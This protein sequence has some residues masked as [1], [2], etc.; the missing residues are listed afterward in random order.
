MRFITQIHHIT[1]FLFLLWFFGS[2]SAQ[3]S[4]TAND[5]VVPYSGYFR[6]GSNLGYLPLGWSNKDAA[7]LVAGNPA[8]GIAGVGARSVRPSLAH[9]VLHQFGDQIE[10]DEFE[11]YFNLGM[12]DLTAFV[13]EPADEWRD[14][15]EY[16]PGHP[17]A[18]FKNLY[19][20]IWDG[21]ANGTPVNDENYFALYMYRVVTKYKDYVK[22]WEIWNEPGFAYTD[23]GWKNPGQPGNWWENDPEPCDYKL[24]API[25]HYIRTLRIAYEVVKY[26]S[27]GDYVVV[28]GLGYPS[29]L[30]AIL[31]NT[32]NPV[33]GGVTPEFPLKGGAYFDV[34]GI[35]SYPSIDGTLRHWDNSVQ[36]WAYMRTSDEAAR[37]IFDDRFAKYEAV[38]ANYGYDGVT[39]PKKLR[40]ITETNVPRKKFTVESLASDEGQCNFLMKA[41]ILNKINDV[42]QMHVY[43]IDDEAYEW[44]I[45]SEFQS[46]GFYKKFSGQPENQVRNHSAIAFKTVAD[47]ITETTYDPQRTAQLNV[48]QGV[49]G[50][51]FKRFDGTYVY[52]LWAKT[53]IDNSEYASATYSFPAEMGISQ[54]TRYDWDYSDTHQSSV[55]DA[56]G[57]PLT[58]RPSFFIVKAGADKPPAVTLH[59]DNHIVSGPFTLTIVF[60]K[61]VTGFSI[62][63]IQVTNSWKSDFA[64]SG[65]SYTVRIHPAE[66]GLVTARVPEA[67]ATDAAGQAN[68]ASL[69]V[70]IVYRYCRPQGNVTYVH[71]KEVRLNALP[72][73]SG[74]N[75]YNDFT[76][77]AFHMDKSQPVSVKL[78]AHKER[79]QDDAYFRVWMDIDKDGI[80][81]PDEVVFQGKGTGSGQVAK[82]YGS[83]HVPTAADTGYTRMRVMVS[84][85]DYPTGPCDDLANGE[86]EDYTALI[87]GTGGQDDCILY[88][89]QNDKLC[90]DWGTPI[91]PNDDHYSVNMT[92]HGLHASGSWLANINGQT[93][94]GSYDQPLDFGPYLIND[95]KFVVY[96]QDAANAGCKVTTLMVPPSPCSDFQ[97][98]PTTNYCV[99]Y[100]DH[101]WAEWI[102]RVQ[103]GDIDNTSFR[104][105]YSDFS[106]LSTDVEKG[107]DY[108]ITL[109]GGFEYYTYDEYWQ[110]WIDFNQNEIFES[111][112]SVLQVKMTAPPNAT[113]EKS[114]TATIHIPQDALSGSTLMRISMSRDHYYDPCDTL[115]HGEYE[116]YRVHI[117]GE[118][119]PQLPG[120][121]VM[122]VPADNATDVPLNTPLAWTTATGATGY[123]LT[124]ATTDGGHDVVDHLDLGDETGFQPFPF[125]HNST[126][127]VKLS[128]YNDQGV[129]D[130]CP[131]S[132][133]T[134]VDTSKNNVSGGDCPESLEGF[135]YLGAF[136]GHHYFISQAMETWKD[137]RVLAEALGGHLASI[138]SQDENDFLQSKLSDIAFIGLSDEHT[139]GTLTW[140]DGTPLDFTKYSTCSW[141]PVNTDANDYATIFPWDGSW[142]FDDHWTKRKFVVEL[143]CTGPPPPPDCN[144]S[145]QVTDIQCTDNGTPDNASDDKFVVTFQISGSDHW[146][147]DMAGT[148]VSGSGTV[149]TVGP[150]PIHLFASNETLPVQVTDL[151]QAG[152]TAQTDVEV[153]NSCSSGGTSGDVDLSLTLTASPPNPGQWSNVTLY[154]TIENA[155]PL[156]ATNIV[157]DFFDQSDN[158]NWSRLGFVSASEPLGT[159]L[160]NWN[161]QWYI[162]T[163]GPGQG[164]TLVYNA[165]TKVATTIPVFAQVSACDQLDGDS[166]PDNNT[167]QNPVE[168]DEAVVYINEAQGIGY[169]IPAFDL[170]SIQDESLFVYPS[171]TTGH[172]TVVSAKPLDKKVEVVSA[173][174]QTLLT[175]KPS[176]GQTFL[177]LD[178]ADLPNGVY[179][180]KCGTKIGRFVKR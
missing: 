47:F 171:P 96:F 9:S 75:P 81:S 116:D 25:Y 147:L 98:V 70:Q 163:L 41:A 165:F 137:A 112:E 122:I 139:E 62:D 108:T 129:N 102:K 94:S 146:Q 143:D 30:D 144:L 109:T 148:Q 111:W 149:T 168:D 161:G 136:G 84:L 53:V 89:D 33:D 120:C 167:S 93:I 117:T 97:G 154:L 38:L 66:P 3:V 95:G 133:F 43:S 72:K 118:T 12:Q 135:A 178:V 145:V 115:A 127:Y 68:L 164:L 160:N 132:V 77:V 37:Q 172:L 80:L 10:L 64:G 152:C 121:S 27:P 18:M 78:V 8:R 76:D 19:K 128:P 14:F 61:P 138:G 67:V 173:L 86:V 56:T 123:Q 88:I 113:P 92:V 114:V 21:G 153:P 31:R 124:L 159:H 73:Y 142:S 45:Q 85:F 103:M 176:A 51:A 49:K 39:Y 166:S 162:P 26:V 28:A 16:C 174:G 55:V 74:K 65:T 101:P 155:G 63:D 100:S 140:V 11:Y 134:T 79:P 105:P 5:V 59:V 50:F 32:D 104:K 106:Y 170:W 35:H 54:L 119:E 52:V 110:V 42:I 1:L 131:Y 99:P 13:G 29:F 44:E 20:P 23:N 157:V 90:D 107:Q 7:D 169:A 58:G 126:F 151:N 24:Y 179:F 83:F 6:P 87:T 175:R 4:F 141:C 22:F 34:L 82:L 177:H 48:P 156:T 71:L 150:I 180:I 69:P 125:P 40:T 36:D 91:D 15:T 158:V 17:S 60:D 46:M 2:L 130:G 57:I